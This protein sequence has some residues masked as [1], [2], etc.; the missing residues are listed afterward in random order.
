MGSNG[1]CLLRGVSDRSKHAT[2]GEVWMEVLVSDS[3]LLATKQQAGSR[4]VIRS[5]WEWPQVC[6][7]PA[8]A[9]LAP[10]RDQVSRSIP[11][12]RVRGYTRN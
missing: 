3:M 2:P 5:V 8:S 7:P 12:G 11:D 10:G 4:G 6:P 9:R 1:R